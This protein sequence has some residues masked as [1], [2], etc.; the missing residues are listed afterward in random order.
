MNGRLSISKTQSKLISK[1]IFKFDRMGIYK[2]DQRLKRMLT[3]GSSTRNFRSF[4]RPRMK[5][6]DKSD[7]EFS[8]NNEVSNT[9]VRDFEKFY[10]LLTVKLLRA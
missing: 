1:F 9:E 7:E 5:S 10:F 8:K 3:R 4:I 6:Q 2:V